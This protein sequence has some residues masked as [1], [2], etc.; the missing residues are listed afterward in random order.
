MAT[1]VAPKRGMAMHIPLCCGRLEC[2]AG[3]CTQASAGC[4]CPLE[5]GGQG[6]AARRAWAVDIHFRTEYR[7]TATCHSG[8]PSPGS[9]PCRL[10][11][12]GCNG[13][14]AE[15]G[16]GDIL[17]LAF[18]DTEIMQ[19]ATCFGDSIICRR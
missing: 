1:M 19:W 9:E 13:S 2:L 5:R 11:M 3:G 15:V 16:K 8:G 7:K 18:Q 12:S 10:T 17:W 4:S 6:R 14:V